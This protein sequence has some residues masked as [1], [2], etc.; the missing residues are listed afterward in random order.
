MSKKAIYVGFPGIGKSHYTKNKT[1]A[2]DL[3]RPDIKD[4]DAYIDL[5][6]KDIENPNVRVILLPSWEWLSRAMVDAGISFTVIYPTI[7]LKEEYMKRYRERGSPEAM[8]NVMDER[9][10]EFVE[11]CSTR[12]SS[13]KIVL[14]R[15]DQ[16][17]EDV[18]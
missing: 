4:P 9:F 13:Y 3:D 17:L 8:I 1:W 7:A 18:I 6:K 10:E 5:I 2:S 15:E 12:E 16:Y 14:T 11:C